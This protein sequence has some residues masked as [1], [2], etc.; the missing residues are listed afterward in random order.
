MEYFLYRDMAS[1]V[2]KNA[3]DENSRK[4]PLRLR[5]GFVFSMWDRRLVA[6]AWIK[7]VI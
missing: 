7:C 4:F 6:K 1:A 5:K 2:T 3:L